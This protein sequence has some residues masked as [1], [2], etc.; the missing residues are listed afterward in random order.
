MSLTAARVSI[1][2]QAKKGDIIEIK[3]LI[4]HPMEPGY[5]PDARGQII[6][7]HIVKLLTVTY[8][9]DEIFRM[10]MHP[11]ISANPFVSFTTV[12]TETGTLMFTWTDD[13]GEV[14]RVEKTLLVTA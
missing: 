10:D 4:R 3:T 6:P 9:G 7:R 13:K 11:A 5:R 14:T 2:E 8:A 1:P 12:A